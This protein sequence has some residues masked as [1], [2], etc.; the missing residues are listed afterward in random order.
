MVAALAWLLGAIGIVWASPRA[1]NG[2][3][4]SSRLAALGV[5]LL[6]AWCG[7][8][9]L[10][11]PGG[12]ASKFW[13]GDA[14]LLKEII[15]EAD[16]GSIALDRFVSLHTA[17]LWAGLGVFSWAC[18]RRLRGRGV[19]QTA[20]FGLMALGVFQSILGIF[21]LKDPGGR[22]CGTFSSPNALGGL[23]AMT[24]PVTLGL[25]LFHSRHRTLR[26]RTG[27]RWWF[28]RLGDSWRA[29]LRPVLW[30]AWG[31]QWVAL[32]FT[33]SIGSTLASTA[34]CGMML[35]WQAKERPESRRFLVA[36]G[37]VLVA[38][39][40][41]FSV[42][43]RSQNVRDRMLGD[44]G[45]LQHS[46]AS[47]IEI[48]RVAWRLCQ[49]FPQGTGPGG[50]ALALPM[51]QTGAYGRYRLDY[52][53]NDTLQFLGDL[54]LPG[55]VPL[56]ILLGLTLWRGAQASWRASGPEG[57]PVWL[58]RGAWL[59]VMAALLHA[60]VE[61][62]LS[63]RP[64]IQV[65][66]VILCGILWGAPPALFPKPEE[67]GAPVRRSLR[68][69]IPNLALLVLA[70]VAIGLSLSAAWAWRLH[71]GAR[72]ATG[73]SIDEHFW[74]RRPVLAADEAPDALRRACRLAPGSSRL[75]RTSAEMRLAM[76]DRRVEDVA[77]S[78]LPSEGESLAADA[79]FDPTLPVHERSLNQAGLALRV[80]EVDMLRAALD[81]ANAAVRLAPWDASA[82]LTR[83]TIL[84]RA[85]ALKP[86][87]PDAEARGRRDLEMAVG[88]YP[89]DASVLAGAC[90]ALSRRANS[91]R[92]V[93]ILLDW[94]SRALDLDASLAW[95]V[96]NAWWTGRVPTSRVLDL[97]DLPIDFLWNLYARL[98]KLNRTENVLQCLLALDRR[99][100][101]AR[102]PEASLL[103]T[104]SMWKRWTIQQAQDRIRLAGEW[105]KR[106]LREG[107]WKGVEASAASR[108]QARH[109]RFQV[110]MDKMELSGTASQVLRRLRLREWAETGRLTPDW[111]LE[112][113]LLE[114]EA[115]MP[116]R[117]IQEPL[118][119]MI[120]MDELGS[121]DLDRLLACRSAL[122]ESPFLT[123]LLVALEAESSG[124]FEE[125]AAALDSSL[126]NGFVPGRLVHRAWLW[127][128]RLLRR[129]GREPEAEEALRAAARACPSD[130]D[131][132]AALMELGEDSGTDLAQGRPELN[133]GFMGGRLVLMHACLENVG[134]QTEG[135]NLHLLWRFR[136][137]LPPDLR[138]DVLI[139]DG[140]GHA[141]AHKTVAVD[142]TPSAK[143]NRGNPPA[144]SAWTWT[145]PL[146]SFAAKG[147]MVE[148][149]LLSAGKLLPSD[150][151]LAVVELNMK[152][153]PR[154]EGGMSR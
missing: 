151:G 106:N 46:K 38:L 108:A 111:T 36:M 102:P 15:G 26:G 31:I 45:E 89:M 54:G 84:L 61:F 12:W 88:L 64:G 81:D 67:P 32:Y 73:L 140:D 41:G 8:Q 94:G 112:W 69:W 87:G 53:H 35:I 119:E 22:I 70:A 17:L 116:V 80:E 2:R 48:W 40:M 143:F 42:H 21:I 4:I 137:G 60:Q 25:V 93:E 71:E 123:A 139:R 101:A 150:D 122:A 115:A 51:Y 146:S 152:K 52:A 16:G 75:R 117:Q 104:P 7:W 153:L 66:F 62:N 110:E 28:H 77:R 9:L 43:A 148:V 23:L 59:A 49:A 145:V 85:A 136:G 57:D 92:D 65:V 129:A 79:P 121:G 55:F 1:G 29:W 91:D 18:S 149:R 44:S 124:R 98:D 30:T 144:G 133:L 39:M 27:F 96:L 76:H 128:S 14:A 68:T 33:G 113:V 72:A 132:E 126:D 100:E 74:F 19:L 141:R 109:D 11:L 13:R 120:L 127:R 130:P 114:L 10:L 95:M 82:K 118:A 103:W 34:A 147:R 3:S 97:P 135:P 125:A 6:V 83:G 105:L 50:T 131:V 107:D 56:V 63:A 78:M 20:M 99:M 37:M 154:M 58:I 138:M 90:S 24:L 86:F 47:R 142:Q 134:K 5:A